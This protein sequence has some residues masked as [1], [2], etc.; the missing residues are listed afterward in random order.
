MRVA[1]VFQTLPILAAG[2]AACGD[3][4]GQPDDTCPGHWRGQ[5]A[6]DGVACA[7]RVPAHPLDRLRQGRAKAGSRNGHL[8]LARFRP[9]VLR[10]PMVAAGLAAGSVILFEAGRSILGLV[11]PDAT[12]C[13]LII[14][15]TPTT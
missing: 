12:R 5:P 10:P 8:I 9:A 2:H 3:L 6:A 11:D 7:G 13:G 4:R 14:G 15:L 1:E